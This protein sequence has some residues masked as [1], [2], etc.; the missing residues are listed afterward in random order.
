[1]HENNPMLNLSS[2]VA[3]YSAAIRKKF[4][5]SIFFYWRLYD[6]G[7]TMLLC[8][9]AKCLKHHYERG[10]LIPAP[11]TMPDEN[12]LVYNHVVEDGPFV[13]AKYDFRHLFNSYDA[14]DITRRHKNYID[15][16]SLSTTDEA[17]DDVH[18]IYLK[19][20]VLFDGFMQDFAVDF[21]DSINMLKKHKITIPKSMRGTY[22]GSDEFDS[23]AYVFPKLTDQEKTCLNYL[24]SGYQAKEI[25]ERLDISKRT[26]EKHLASIRAKMEC[27]NNVEVVTKHLAWRHRFLEKSDDALIRHVESSINTDQNLASLTVRQRDC[28]LALIQGNTIKQLAYKFQISMRT[29]EKHFEHI[30]VKLNCNSYLDIIAKYCSD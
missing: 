6:D 27:F 10:H 22:V 14:M 13:Q 21:R 7:S 8:D 11:L 28:L 23:K 20:Q 26:A 5:L 18:T 30:K 15:G 24:T 19:N 3:N 16:F 17:T 9:N 4:N 2:E 25:S 12:Q 29:A 1:M